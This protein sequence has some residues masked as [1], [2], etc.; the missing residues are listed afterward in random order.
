MRLG[1]GRAGAAAALGVLALGAGA[2]LV[3]PVR[4]AV[5]EA[6]RALSLPDARRAVEAARTWLRGFGPWAPVASAAL[7]VLQAVVA[8]LPAFVITFANGL[9]FGWAWGALLSWSSA[10]AG[11]ALCFW[12]SRALGRP[13]VERL[14]GGAAALERADRFFARH[15]RW[16]V[17]LARLLPFVPF[18]LVSYGAGLTAIGFWPFLAAT[19]LGQLPAT[20]LYSYL[21]E[22]LTGSVRV[23]CWGFS[24]ATALLALYW[25]AGRRALRG[26]AE[27]RAAPLPGA[28]RG[29]GR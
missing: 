24:L 11:A 20:L 29:G 21:G 13:A 4:A 9:L 14:A 5:D 8:P 19:G 17:L 15:G 25:L 3:P 2:Y 6:V 23:L 12:L 28:G 10:L 22:S 26:A 7:M 18:D 1:G 27:A 16:A